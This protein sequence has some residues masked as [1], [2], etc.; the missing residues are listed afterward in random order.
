MAT[1]LSQVATNQLETDFRLNQVTDKLDAT[2]DQFR[3]LVTQQLATDARLDRVTERLD[4]VVEAISGLTVETDSLRDIVMHFV[5][6]GERDREQAAAD[7]Q[8]AAADRQQA[9]QDRQAWQAETRR[10]WEYLRDRNG[11]S[12]TPN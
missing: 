12:N 1:N 4:Q 5:Q 9:A 2:A 11:G 10:I 6:I 7:R 3:Q 8:Q